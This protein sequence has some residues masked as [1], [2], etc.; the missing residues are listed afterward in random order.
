M[1]TYKQLN[2]STNSLEPYISAETME[3]HWEKH[4]KGY[5]D[6]YN[7]LIQKDI[8]NKEVLKNQ[9]NQIKNHELFFDNLTPYQKIYQLILNRY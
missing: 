5:V 6:T 1:M 4:Y 2:Y 3:Y 9:F 8:V 7:S